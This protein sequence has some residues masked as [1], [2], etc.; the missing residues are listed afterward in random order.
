MR[1]FVDA[2][3]KNGVAACAFITTNKNGTLATHAQTSGKR[4][5]DGEFPY[6]RMFAAELLGVVVAL[7]AVRDREIEIV[8]DQRDVVRGINGDRY[9]I[10]HNL[11][12]Q[13][14]WV[15]FDRIR[16]GRTVTGVLPNKKNKGLHGIVHRMAR[17]EV[18]RSVRKR[19]KVPVP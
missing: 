4:Y 8:C 19:D 2:S 12:W 15:E 6:H 1:I 16:D 17:A 5:L 7:S 13:D 3:A 18:R 9:P 11:D 14:L 10:S